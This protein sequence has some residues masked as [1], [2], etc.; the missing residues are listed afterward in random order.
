MPTLKDMIKPSQ[1]TRAHSVCLFV[2]LSLMKECRM[3]GVLEI[4]LFIYFESLRFR[5]QLCVD[6]WVSYYDY[7]AQSIF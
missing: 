2:W 6:I 7:S 3:C 5:R 4:Y 1:R